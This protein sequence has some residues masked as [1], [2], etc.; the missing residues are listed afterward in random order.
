MP[1][2]WHTFVVGFQKLL[3]NTGNESQLHAEMY[4]FEFHNKVHI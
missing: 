3:S 4:V 1:V 2:D